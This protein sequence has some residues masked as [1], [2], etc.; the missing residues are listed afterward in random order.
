MLAAGTTWGQVIAQIFLKHLSCTL[1]LHL[2]WESDLDRAG[3]G[4]PDGGGTVAGGGPLAWGAE[5][6][7]EGRV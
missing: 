7:R 1:D 2:R 5:L 3:F 6:G 4:N